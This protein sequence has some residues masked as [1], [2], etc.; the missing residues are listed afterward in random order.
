M[1]EKGRT[2]PFGG[3]DLNGRSWHSSYDQEGAKPVGFAPVTPSNWPSVASGDGAGA[4]V[5][6]E[7]LA[8]ALLAAGGGTVTITAEPAREQSEEAAVVVL[9]PRPAERETRPL[10]RSLS[11][12]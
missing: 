7:D 1:T 8:Q 9:E 3:R 2:E 4:K 5:T 11:P 6:A 12:P 10:G